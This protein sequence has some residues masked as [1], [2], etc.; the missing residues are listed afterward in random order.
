M[1]ASIIKELIEQGV[2]VFLAQAAFPSYL[3]GLLPK[4]AFIEADP[5]NTVDLLT[6]VIVFAH[7]RNV[8][9]DGV[10]TY[11]EHAVPNTAIL[12]QMLG[13]PGIDP[14]IAYRSSNL[15]VAMREI[16]RSNDI[17]APKYLFL[18]DLTTDSLEAAR[19]FLGGDVIIKPV[20]GNNSHGVV[21]VRREDNLGDIIDYL[22]RSCTVKHEEAF[23]NLGKAFLVESYLEGKQISV[24]GIIENGTVHFAG[25]TEIVISPPYFT[26]SANYI[27]PRIIKDEY[28][29]SQQYCQRVIETLNFDN[30]G[31]HC[32]LKLTNTGPVLIE[33]AC[34]APGGK[35]MQG[36]HIAYGVDFVG[37]M[38]DLWLGN[39]VSLYHKHLVHIYQAGV[40]PEGEGRLVTLEG[41]EEA[42]N[43][44]GVNEV[45]PVMQ[46]GQR[47]IAPPDTP[48]P[49]YY[50]CVEGSTP[51]ELGSRIDKIKETIKYSIV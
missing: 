9:F 5:Y 41:I 48:V 33:I 23:K 31:F 49:I 39:P 6:R 26:A 50:F 47:V 36:Y 42:K 18:D 43:L 8:R 11:F 30:C 45:T 19:E 51:Q 15:K 7:E 16:S 38:A 25:I 10:G 28:E 12:A 37:A 29:I 20:S 4:E 44:P 2:E 46:A 34:R 24:D 14:G 1:K 22:N 13:L 32:E 3:A 17:A 35:I 27:P 21:R 40:F